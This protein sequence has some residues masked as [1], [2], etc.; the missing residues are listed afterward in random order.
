MLFYIIVMIFE[1]MLGRLGY[2][3][4]VMYFYWLNCFVNLFICFYCNSRVNIGVCFFNL[5]FFGIL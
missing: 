3:V 1:V 4:S 5:Y 2:L